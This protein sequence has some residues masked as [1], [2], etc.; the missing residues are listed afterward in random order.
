[1]VNPNS[2][3]DIATDQIST[4]FLCKFYQDPSVHATTTTKPFI[5]SKL[6]WPRVKRPFSLQ[7]THIIKFMCITYI[8]LKQHAFCKMIEKSMFDQRKQKDKSRKQ[9]FSKPHDAA[10]EVKD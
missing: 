6:G 5:P 3:I 7:S 8:L 2:I 4:A 9:Y 10:M 1:M